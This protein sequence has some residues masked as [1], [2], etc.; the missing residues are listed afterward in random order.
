MKKYVSHTLSMLS[1][2]GLLAMAITQINAMTIPHN[3]VNSTP[4]QTPAEALYSAVLS[5]KSEKVMGL[6]ASI[7]DNQKYELMET[8]NK[9]YKKTI[10]KI[11]VE[12]NN[13]A[14]V[15]LLLNGLSSSQKYD[16][17]KAPVC[18]ANLLSKATNNGNIEIVT[19]LLKN[20][21][22]EQ[23]TDLIL[24]VPFEHSLSKHRMYPGILDILKIALE[25]LRAQNNGYGVQDKPNLFKN[26]IK[27]FNFRIRRKRCEGF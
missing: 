11:A 22:S 20:L 23:K 19:E 10:L 7:S 15:T 21:S 4:K 6:L 8:A 9:I 25:P 5:N 13:L 16:L 18:Y 3:L 14:I 1:I 17:L 27:N 2:G 26:K 24:T 12:K